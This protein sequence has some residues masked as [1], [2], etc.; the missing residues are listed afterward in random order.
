MKGKNHTKESI[1]K[2]RNTKFKRWKE[3]KYIINKISKAELKVK[4][5]LEFNKI[6]FIHQYPYPLGV[7][8]FYLSNLNLIIQCY[9]DYWH[10]KSDYIERDKKQNKWFTDNGYNVLILNSEK[11]LED[12]IKGVIEF[13]RN[14]NTI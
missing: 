10:S 2:I 8:D 12:G 3:G 1:D 11:I 6:K 13:V 14:K 5:Q 4:E 7:A 9:G